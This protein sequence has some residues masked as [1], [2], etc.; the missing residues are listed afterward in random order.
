[1]LL[2]S[3]EATSNRQKCNKVFKNGPS[4]T[5]GRQSLK[6]VKGYSLPKTD[7]FPSNSLKAIFHKF[8]LAHSGILC[9]K[10]SLVN[11]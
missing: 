10:Y 2:A 8:Y 1:M 11:P 9:P 6:N 4:K 5:C 3:Q 7:H